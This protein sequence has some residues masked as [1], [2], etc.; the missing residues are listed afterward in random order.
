MPWDIWKNENGEH[1]V[2]KKNPDGSK[3]EKE[4]C[5]PTEDEAKDQL[6][7]LYASE[8]KS[9]KEKEELKEHELEK[10]ESSEEKM[11]EVASATS[12]RFSVPTIGAQT[13]DDLDEQREIEE[14][15]RAF[16]EDSE[17]FISLFKN[18]VY[19][20]EMK[21]AERGKKV[22]ELANGYA[23]RIEEN[24]NKE[25]KDKEIDQKG[26]L[27]EQI[28]K[29]VSQLV[30]RLSPKNK[31]K[32]PAQE[33]FTVFKDKEGH[34]RW[35]AKYS[36]NFRDDEEEIIAEKSHKRFVELVDKGLAPYPSLLLWHEKAWELGD[37]DWVAYDDA[38]FALASGPVKKEAEGVAQWLSKQKDIRMSH[39]MPRS[40]IK[41]DESD[42]SVIIEHETREVSILPKAK[43]ANK[44]T[45]MYII[46]KELQEDNHMAIP[47]EKKKTILDWGI[48][49]DVLGDLEKINALEA[50]AAVEADIDRKEKDEVDEKESEDKEDTSTKEEEVSEEQE[51]AEEQ[52]E[53]ELS[54]EE[55][56]EALKMVA[57]NVEKLAKAT[58]E[59]FA[60][61]E[62]QIEKSDE[63]AKEELNKVLGDTPPA[64]LAGMLAK[65][66]SAIGS[67]ETEV[68]GR[69]SLAQDK[70]K[71]AESEDFG[72]FPAPFLNKMVSQKEEVE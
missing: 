36:N 46:E 23:D 22:V 44:L 9:M 51:E 15:M 17:D 68:D 63:K 66:F 72:P 10:E 24:F 26:G 34:L 28:H 62:E 32:E 64:S 8:D 70:P 14:K 67:E 38:G 54:R 18:I 49:D 45:G 16:E 50:E 2:H 56:F 41:R 40:T 60:S 47:K 71:E 55:V 11:A 48:D 37:A 25:M 13:F 39:G 69:T 59:R 20:G 42:P 27:I 53:K 43:A 7:A 19:N 33:G 65:N 58:D 52:E 61:L 31:D 21:F 29:G 1:C 4:G 35:I 6:S 30:E 5:H 3:G 57:D 12:D